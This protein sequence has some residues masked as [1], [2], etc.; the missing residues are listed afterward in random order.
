[1]NRKGG[2]SGKTNKK[3]CE[4]YSWKLLAKTR[5]KL[6]NV[7]NKQILKV[8]RARLLFSLLKLVSTKV[9]VVPKVMLH[10][11]VVWKCKLKICKYL[12]VRP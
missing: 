12:L 2:R 9:K 4:E 6:M 5:R 3:T 8:S 11:R 7:L 1:M 10:W